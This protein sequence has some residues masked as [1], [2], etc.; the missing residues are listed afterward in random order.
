MTQAEVEWRRQNYGSSFEDDDEENYTD[1]KCDTEDD[2]NE[3][4]KIQF[5]PDRLEATRGAWEDIAA[6]AAATAADDIAAGI[7][8]SSED[9]N[10][11]NHIEDLQLAVE[12]CLEI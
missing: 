10:S 3:A 9:L 1:R 4:R 2:L 5:S 12:K 11:V 6:P 7:T 8:L